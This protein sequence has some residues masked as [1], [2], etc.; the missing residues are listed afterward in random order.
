MEGISLEL[1]NCWELVVSK[2][3]FLNWIY[4][5]A[6]PVSYKKCLI[7]RM[8]KSLRT[9]TYI[10]SV[11]DFLMTIKWRPLQIL[12]NSNEQKNLIRT[13]QLHISTFLMDFRLLLLYWLGADKGLTQ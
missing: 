12:S 3:L 11:S 8:F 13:M 4:S 2:R 6:T 5:I 9:V 10:V 7:S 1:F